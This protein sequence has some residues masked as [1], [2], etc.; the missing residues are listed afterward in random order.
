MKVKLII[1]I[2]AMVGIIILAAFGS[3]LKGVAVK[4]MAKEL[5]EYSCGEGNICTSCI[6]ESQTCSCGTDICNC[7]NKTVNK[8]E[9]GFFNQF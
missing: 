8:E 4:G 7:G 9:C 6:I 5:P 3:G 1:I 2:L